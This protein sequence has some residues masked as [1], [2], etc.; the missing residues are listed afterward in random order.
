MHT[1]SEKK[2][3]ATLASCVDWIKNAAL[4]F[5]IGLGESE[6]RLPFECVCWLWWARWTFVPNSLPIKKKSTSLSIK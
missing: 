4:V 1:K 2:A 3:L 6:R 5:I